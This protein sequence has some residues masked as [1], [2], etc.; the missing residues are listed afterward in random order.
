MVHPKLKNTAYVVLATAHPC[1]FP[2]VFEELEIAIEEPKQ[3]KE[4]Y[5]KEKIS[6]DMRNSFEEFKAF[7]MG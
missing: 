3:M 2:D 4:L 5:Q 7:L 1:K 6:L